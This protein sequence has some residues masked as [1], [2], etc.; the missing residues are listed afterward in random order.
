MPN[1]TRS[2]TSATR[3][4][5]SKRPVKGRA[6]RSLALL[7]A[8]LAGAESDANRGRSLILLEELETALHPGATRVLLDAMSEASE[9]SQVVVTT[10]S[11]DLLDQKDIP[12][13]SVLAVEAEEGVARI[14]PIDE[15]GRS[16]IRDR[17]FTAG[18][19]LRT[20]GLHP[21]GAEAGGASLDGRMGQASVHCLHR[22][23]RWRGRGSPGARSAPAG[24]WRR[25]VS[26]LHCRVTPRPRGRS[27]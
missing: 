16:A 26:N 14:G 17:L 2:A 11:P 23:G 6:Q 3:Y 22:R 27:D 21:T 20:A 13:D 12:E 7:V 8:L 19:L 24:W 18:D 9:H 15:V 1:A 4:A 5:E 25:R 10:H